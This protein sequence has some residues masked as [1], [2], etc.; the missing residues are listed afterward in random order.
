MTDVDFIDFI[1]TADPL[2]RAPRLAYVFTLSPKLA[3]PV[4]GK[5][6]PNFQ[7]AISYL[8]QYEGRVDSLMDAL[9]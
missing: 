8:R 6:H 7:R 4:P 2:L 1:P 9:Q 3:D 5:N